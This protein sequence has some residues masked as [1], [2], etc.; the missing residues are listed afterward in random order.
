MADLDEVTYWINR[1]A[2]GDQEAA[3]AIWEGYFSKLVRYARR[4][5]DDMPRRAVDE[6]D[7]AISAMYSFCRG[8]EAGRFEKVDDR[9]DL[10]KLLV[11]ITARKAYAV[12]KRHYREKR[13]KG[14]VRGESVFQR[15]DD[16]E[17]RSAGI[18]QVLGSEP[19]PEL[20]NMVVENT[21][22]L[23]DALD[24]ETLRQVAIMKLEGQTNVE[25]AQ[26]LGCVARTVERK[27]ERIRGKW[28]REGL[29]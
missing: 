11:T 2:E 15:P 10:W 29:V 19:T 14:R 5:L 6:E 20:A 9:E 7:V 24:D 8:L 17:F 25:I 13:G 23:L 18:G 27:L 1:L 16:D 21:R 4:K 26:K 28:S 22:E 12:R 3:H